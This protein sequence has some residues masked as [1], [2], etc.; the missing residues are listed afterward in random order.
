MGHGTAAGEFSRRPLFAGCRCC[1]GFYLRAVAGRA[2][3][4][5]GN[6]GR[7]DDRCGS[8]ALDFETGD[9]RDDGARRRR[10]STASIAVAQPLPLGKNLA[11]DVSPPWLVGLTAMVI[12]LGFF[13]AGH[14]LSI[15]LAE[16]Y[17]Q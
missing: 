4:G 13:A 3:C 11:L 8:A 5:H 9:A 2:W 6:V 17:T 14:D 10:M 12:G 16:G 1:G 7:H 15:S